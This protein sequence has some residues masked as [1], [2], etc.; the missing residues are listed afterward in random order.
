MQNVGG[1][2]ENETPTCHLQTQTCTLTET[3]YLRLLMTSP[4][5]HLTSRRLSA[6]TRWRRGPGTRLNQRTLSHILYLGKATCIKASA[7]R[8]WNRFQQITD[9]VVAAHFSLDWEIISHATSPGTVRGISQIGMRAIEPHVGNITAHSAA[10]VV[11]NNI[12][13]SAVFDHGR[14]SVFCFFSKDAFNP[15][16]YTPPPHSPVECLARQI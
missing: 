3:R 10:L 6:G 14:F 1:S 13:K 9:H 7:G 11:G 15:A 2:K 5:W 16:R 12:K 8:R 4:P